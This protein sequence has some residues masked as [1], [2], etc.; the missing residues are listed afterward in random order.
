M[1]G[2][3]LGPMRVLS[4]TMDIHDPKMHRTM[5]AP[6]RIVGICKE[7]REWVDHAPGCSHFRPE[8]YVTRAQ[9]AES[10]EKWARERAAHWL[11]ELQRAHGKIAMLK[12]QIRAM[13]KKAT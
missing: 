7:C 3:P 8:D 6:S 11:G 4:T 13:R 2:S 5:N 10:R 12:D 1:S 9:R